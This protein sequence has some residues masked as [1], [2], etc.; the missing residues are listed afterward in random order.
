MENNWRKKHLEELKSLVGNWIA[1]ERDGD[2]LA[3]DRSQKTVIK[4]ADETGKSYVLFHIHP[5]DVD[6]EKIRLIGFRF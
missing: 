6:P 3:W 1:Y 2:I 5:R 4:N